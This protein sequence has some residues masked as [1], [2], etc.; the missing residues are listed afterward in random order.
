MSTLALIDTAIGFTFIF[1]TY[2]V[3]CSAMVEWVSATFQRRSRLLGDALEDLLG[4]SLKRKF[5]QHRLILG[6]RG[7]RLFRPTAYPDY[8]PNEVFAL[9]FMNLTMDFTPGPPG[10]AGS[11][12][13][14]ST[15]SDADKE[16]AAS[17][18]QGTNNVGPVQARLE[19]WFNDAMETATG[20]YKRVSQLY[21]IGAALI[22]TVAFQIDALALLQDLYANVPLREHIVEL[23]QRA[24]TAAIKISGHSPLSLPIGWIPSTKGFPG[25]PAAWPGYVLSVIGLSFGAPFWFDLLKRLVNLRQSGTPPDE[26]RST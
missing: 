24:D 19:R 18:M 11:V 8:L 20:R 17:M 26:R 25:D 4:P 7:N 13:L 2:S 23:A 12:T 16:L 5:G 6:L 22:V 9:A 1:A 15:L 10:G 3:V 21:A 14:K